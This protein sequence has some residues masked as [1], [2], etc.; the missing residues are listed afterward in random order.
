MMSFDCVMETYPGRRVMT[1]EKAIYVNGVCYRFPAR[2]VV[3]ICNDGGD[4]AYL[5]HALDSGIVP[6]IAR[7][8]K[9]G[10]AATAQAVIPS[11]TC[12]NNVCPS[13]PAVHRRCTGF[14]AT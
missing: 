1:C 9:S 7:F 13:S 5:E 2:P 8:M 11:F 10:F 12:P 14:P 6:N 3:V 4:P